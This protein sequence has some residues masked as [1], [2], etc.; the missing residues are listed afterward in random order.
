MVVPYHE[1]RD[2][3]EGSP[4]RGQGAAGVLVALAALEF[5]AELA[6]RLGG[7]DLGQDGPAGAEQGVQAAFEGPE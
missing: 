2:A 7:V 3:G 1:K 4:S 5:Q 6:E